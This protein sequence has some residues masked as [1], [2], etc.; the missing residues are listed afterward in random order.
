MPA[1][2]KI[3]GQVDPKMRIAIKRQNTRLKTVLAEFG[4]LKNFRSHLSRT[5]I[6]EDQWYRENCINREFLG[7]ALEETL[8][9]PFPLY[10]V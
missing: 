9:M 10:N 7:N 6:T 5:N 2:A 1:P 3:L 4:S 8:S